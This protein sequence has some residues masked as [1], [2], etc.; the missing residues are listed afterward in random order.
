MLLHQGRMMS[1][2]SD[3]DKCV[4]KLR[5]YIKT[6]DIKSDEASILSQ[7]QVIQLQSDLLVCGFVKKYTSFL[8]PPY[9]MEVLSITLR[10][11]VGE[12]I[13][14]MHPSPLL[15]AVEF[16]Y[17]LPIVVSLLKGMERNTSHARHRY[18]GDVRT[19]EGWSAFKLAWKRGHH[20]TVSL[21]ARMLKHFAG[22]KKESNSTYWNLR[23]E[24]P[25]EIEEA[26]RIELYKDGDYK[27]ISAF[28][29]EGN[30]WNIH[31]KHIVLDFVKWA[32]DEDKVDLVRRLMDDKIVD[33]QRSYKTRYWL[34]YSPSYTERTPLWIAFKARHYEMMEMMITEGSADVNSQRHSDLF[35]M[36]NVAVRDNLV[37]MFQLLLKHGANVHEKDGKGRTPLFIAAQ[38]NMIGAIQ[39]LLKNNYN[40][41]APLRIV[42]QNNLIRFVWLPI[43]HK[44]VL[45]H[46][47]CSS[48]KT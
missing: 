45:V 6:H 48:A 39:F 30:E 34:G 33:V 19:E 1:I 11:F 27:S 18:L 43:E 25:R 5:E 23:R 29:A 37:G 12:N 15:T 36:L 28:L 8:T 41:R 16:G 20:I 13:D 47:N 3:E 26:A 24:F 17:L 4:D 22:E 40:G 31:S 42:E 14:Q 35:T 32:C 9:P 2:L 21:M 46:C 44:V 38:F 10:Y 7:I